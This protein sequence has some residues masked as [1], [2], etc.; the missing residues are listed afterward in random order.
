MMEKKFTF[1]TFGSFFLCCERGRKLHRE[2][3]EEERTVE[4]LPEKEEM[5]GG[6]VGWV[7]VQIKIYH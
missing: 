2:V 1:V 7:E 4:S 6:G 5:R 3:G